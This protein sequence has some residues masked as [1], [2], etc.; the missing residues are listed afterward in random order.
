MSDW[1]SMMEGNYELG[2]PEGLKAATGASFGFNQL[3]DMEDMEELDKGVFLLL[4][5][6]N[7]WCTR[8]AKVQFFIYQ[9]SQEQRYSQFVA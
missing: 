1:L 2:R 6:H 4:G 8:T 3:N 7:A 9:N 5:P